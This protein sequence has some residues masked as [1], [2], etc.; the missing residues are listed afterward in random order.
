MW[1]LLTCF[2]PTVLTLDGRGERTKS[3]ETL[4]TY[5][6]DKHMRLA[7]MLF[8]LAVW[9]TLGVRFKSAGGAD[10]F[11]APVPVLDFELTWINI[12]IQ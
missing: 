4:C 8:C 1:V 2:S 5:K 11:G 3:S 12:F 9:L 7:L 6:H 10:P